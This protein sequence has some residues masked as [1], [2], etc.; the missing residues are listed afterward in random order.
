MHELSVVWLETI[1]FKSLW[2]GSQGEAIKLFTAYCRD[3]V[4]CLDTAGTKPG[5]LKG[6]DDI[7]A[8]EEVIF[9]LPEEESMQ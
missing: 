8:P 4:S 9:S 6:V 3:G 1:I 5:I 2:D 7:C